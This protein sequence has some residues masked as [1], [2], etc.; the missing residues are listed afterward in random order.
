MLL[1]RQGPESTSRVGREKSKEHRGVL[2][3]RTKVV[4]HQRAKVVDAISPVAQEWAH[5]FYTNF[6]F[7]FWERPGRSGFQ[8]ARGPPPCVHDF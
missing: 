4:E 3:E 7:M 1:A 6:S 5:E 8:N 2:H